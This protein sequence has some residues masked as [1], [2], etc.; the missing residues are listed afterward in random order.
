MI[1][2]TDNENTSY[3]PKHSAIKRY[4]L[5]LRPFVQRTL[6]ICI[7]IFL[8]VL[9][10]GALTGGVRQFTY[11]ATLGQQVETIVQLVCGLLSL[12]TVFTCFWWRK[13]AMQIRLAWGISLVTAAGLSSLVWGPPMLLTTLIFILVGLFVSLIIIWALQ[14]L[15]ADDISTGE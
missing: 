1:R 13:W 3:M 11:S 8:I 6:L 9:A 7:M 2:I 12:L 10:W 15:S 4:P 14:R 5:N